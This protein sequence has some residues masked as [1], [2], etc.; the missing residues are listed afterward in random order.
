M[1]FGSCGDVNPSCFCIAVWFGRGS[2]RVV[3]AARGSACVVIQATD[4]GEIWVEGCHTAIVAQLV[5]LVSYSFIVTSVSG[6]T[7]VPIF[8]TAPVFAFGSRPG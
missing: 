1:E 5:S 6:V 3:W 4:R 2:A 7:G 8:P